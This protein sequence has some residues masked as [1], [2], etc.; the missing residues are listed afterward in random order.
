MKF[1]HNPFRNFQ[2]SW[3]NGRVFVE[4]TVDD[5]A[6][7]AANQ[8]KTKQQKIENKETEKNVDAIL[9][10]PLAF[11]IR[12]IKQLEEGIQEF[13]VVQMKKFSNLVEYHLTL[14]S[15]D[16]DSSSARSLL[17]IYQSPNLRKNIRPKVRETIE[18]LTGN[19]T[20]KFQKI[21]NKTT[22][23]W[24]DS[25]TL[26]VSI[27]YRDL[28]DIENPAF[29][30]VLE[31]A[32]KKLKERRDDF[33]GRLDVTEVE[34]QVK[35]VI[36][37]G[38]AQR[39]LTQ[40]DKLLLLEIERIFPNE[41]MD[42]VGKEKEYAQWKTIKK[43]TLEKLFRDLEKELQKPKNYLLWE[44]LQDLDVSPEREEEIQSITLRRNAAQ[45]LTFA[46]EQEVLVRT[47]WN[48]LKEIEKDTEGRFTPKE[49]S[50]EG[51]V[52]LKDSKELDEIIQKKKSLEE[53]KRTVEESICKSAIEKNETDE[54]STKEDSR[55]VELGKKYKETKGK[56][57]AVIEKTKALL[58]KE[59][60]EE[61]NNVLQKNVEERTE[62]R[63]QTQDAD[64]QK[65]IDKEIALLKKGQESFTK[66]IESAEEEKQYKN[67][68]QEIQKNVDRA[69]KSI[70]GLEAITQD[71]SLKNM[72]KDI[73]FIQ[74]WEDVSSELDD[75][76]SKE[77]LAREAL[78]SMVDLTEDSKKSI[79]DL[80][81]QI[82]EFRG[83]Q[84]ALQ[85]ESDNFQKYS[86]IYSDPRKKSA[87]I[88]DDFV[89]KLEGRMQAHQLRASDL[90]VLWDIRNDEK[91]KQK[92]TKEIPAQYG[93]LHDKLEAVLFGPNGHIDQI[94]SELKE[95]SL[96][97]WMGILNEKLSNVTLKSKLKEKGFDLSEAFKEQ[98]KENIGMDVNG[99]LEGSKLHF[100][101]R[102]KERLEKSIVN[103]HREDEQEKAKEI[104]EAYWDNATVKV[105]SKKDLDDLKGNQNWYL[106]MKQSTSLSVE[107]KRETYNKIIDDKQNT[108]LYKDAKG[109]KEKELLKKS[110]DVSEGH[111][112]KGKVIEDKEYGKVFIPG[113][114]DLAE[115]SIKTQR[116]Q[117]QIKDTT[118]ALQEK[119]RDF[120][121][122]IETF[123]R[124]K[125]LE[126][127]NLSFDQETLADDLR[128]IVASW[129]GEK[130]VLKQ[131]LA[132]QKALCI[133]HADGHPQKKVFIDLFV[134]EHFG[135]IETIVSHTDDIFSKLKEEAEKTQ[136]QLDGSK[137]YFFELGEQLGLIYNHSNF[138]DGLMAQESERI[139]KDF[140]SNEKVVNFLKQEKLFK[141]K[142]E[143]KTRFRN[144]RG[145][146]N[147]KFQQYRKNI[148]A[149]DRIIEKDIGLDDGDFVE[150]YGMDKSAARKV[151]QSH[152]LQQDTFE[153]NW[154]KFTNGNAETGFED[155]WFNEY[156]Q[157]VREND[158]T[159]MNAVLDKL[160]SIEN[161]ADIVE[162]AEISSARLADF[163]REYEKQKKNKSFWN[164]EL[165]KTAFS[166]Y[167]IYRVIKESFDA[168]EKHW[169][170][171]SDSSVAKIGVSFW[172]ENNRWGREFSRMQEESEETRYK[173]FETQYRD[174]PG[175]EILDAINGSKNQ[176]MVRGCI[177]LLSEKGFLNWED[178]ILWRAFNKLSGHTYFNIPEDQSLSPHQIKEKVKMA[179]ENIWTPEVFRQWDAGLDGN[180]KKA[181]EQFD[182]D[183][184]KYEN[185][186]QPRTAILAGMLQKWSRGESKGVDPAQYEH[187]IFASF[188][189]G[190]MNGQPD[191][192]WYFLIMGIATRNPRTGQSLL[193]K[194][195]LMR[196]NKD[197][198]QRFPFID[199][200][201]D[202]ES[203]KLNGRIVPEGTPGTEGKSTLWTENDYRCWAKMLG[204]GNGSFNPTVPPADSR[205]ESFFYQ[206]INE[207]ITCKQRAQ[208]MGRFSQAPDHDD[209][210]NYQSVWDHNRIVENINIESSGL[211]KLSE[212]F[213]R[214][215][216]S[217]FDKYVLNKKAMIDNGDI[218]W[219]GQAQWDGPNGDR[220]RHLLEIGKSVKVALSVTQFLQGNKTTDRGTTTF[221][222]D[223]W[224]KDSG[225]SAYAEENRGLINS[226]ARSLLEDGGEEAEFEEIF[227]FQSRQKF[228]ATRD[229]R[230]RGVHQEDWKKINTKVS[231]LL[232]TDESEQKYFKDT[233][234]IEKALNIYCSNSK[235]SIPDYLRI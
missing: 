19:Q 184:A 151:I 46:K 36:E 111:L 40:E 52:S 66:I 181:K 50:L 207:S 229:S 138:R 212:D 64:E 118:F 159:K 234:L 28:E 30:E 121:K 170:R 109:V 63:T 54:D 6:A 195:A 59:K 186:D 162:T 177:N 205:T 208:R 92:F 103:M 126:R 182:G 168:Q 153:D 45:F 26:Q 81:T 41:R 226:F 211:S 222:N 82:D 97:E 93:E 194:D 76:R 157:S 29:K 179:C 99:L 189:D 113:K 84:D 18:K 165:N 140:E 75:I 221:D 60:L 11:S 14:A 47:H 34:G 117:E 16:I 108:R 187:F 102:I 43:D 155:D 191:Q 39:P 141:D 8:D 150:K 174:S 7:K 68:F 73:E 223:E 203:P 94:V 216:L 142:D 163:L 232:D 37:E 204:T 115:L 172:G 132:E 89:K 202:K 27:L 57:E 188:R 178:P 134:N 206:V 144:L 65:Q 120:Q 101:D 137:E 78:L 199:F 1:L 227:D 133:E 145:T 98:S 4:G 214:S 86:E 183:F 31:E 87:E 167:D 230:E 190:K 125:E 143:F 24:T 146:Y 9:R 198:L 91:T 173:E 180:L 95:D 22:T 61:A 88:S 156:E 224:E 116:N 196:A 72:G 42:W 218:E 185:D 161:M 135:K 209:G 124:T 71:L 136:Y 80:E 217:G 85:K 70:K 129:P 197:F 175:W 77:R 100:R 38:S 23:S 35:Q 219:K 112:R 152:L 201:A 228:G 192:R 21:V 67:Y 105:E 62:K 131:N 53:K 74:H 5:D 69:T 213:W 149:A 154:K 123:Y 12:H 158:E 96:S 171:K 176:D 90:D 220:N 2:T 44:V 169:K 119:L 104:L 164:F 110:F 49:F 160:K 13:D 107:Q 166:I 83:K 17:K 200:L 106:A 48:L 33:L 128:T 20:E 3:K 114:D 225:Y 56:E 25:E 193:P 231:R 147:S 233:P 210:I 32:K 122:K 15:R 51:E 215:W 235:N 58:S 10:N 139:Q 127:I 130:S 148:N 79:K 55:I